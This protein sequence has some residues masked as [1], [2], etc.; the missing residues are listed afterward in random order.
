M[1]IAHSLLRV[2]S[3]APKFSS[4]AKAP[5]GCRH[6]QEYS[7]GG[8]S[9][10][11]M[12]RRPRGGRG[13]RSRGRG[14]TSRGGGRG[15]RP[16]TE[17]TTANQLTQR[18]ESFPSESTPRNAG[19]GSNSPR[20]NLF[21]G[22]YTIPNVGFS[23]SPP[24]QESFPSDPALGYGRD[25]PQRDI[26]PSDSNVSFG[27]N[28]PQREPFPSDS[29]PSDAGFGRK[30]PPH[31]HFARDSTPPNV[32]FC[33]SPP[34]HSSIPN[35]PTSGNS[36]RHDSFIVDTTPLNIDFGAHSSDPNTAYPPA[37]QFRRERATPKQTTWQDFEKEELSKGV[38]LGKHKQMPSPG[39]EKGGPDDK[40]LRLDAEV[41][42]QEQ[43]GLAGS[44]GT[45]TSNQGEDS[46][47]KDGDL[48]VEGSKDGDPRGK[49]SKVKKVCLVVYRFPTFTQSPSS[50]LCPVGVTGL[51]RKQCVRYCVSHLE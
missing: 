18:H 11:D 41:Q 17:D 13:G 5:V 22:E 14:G 20:N 46:R 29:V 23:H 30:L 40:Q 15:R 48:G 31:D 21:S 34:W 28:P 44:A 2:L 24:Q 27:R 4:F 26:F 47:E 43:E 33:Q 49:K 25:P 42:S 39:S 36:P 7:F 10:Q 3:R 51:L 8:Q 35:D 32:G 37:A 9:H 1:K 45:G 38:S 6:L 50:L 19:F 12:Y 16:N